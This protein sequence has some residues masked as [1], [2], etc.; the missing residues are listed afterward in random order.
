M[1]TPMGNPCGEIDGIEYE[2]LDGSLELRFS[3]DGATGT[4]NFHID[5]NDRR[6]FAEALT[7]IYINGSGTVIQVPPKTFPGYD[8]LKCQDVVVRGVKLNPDNSGGYLYARVDAVYSPDGKGGGGGGGGSNEQDSLLTEE[9]D[10]YYESI[11]APEMQYFWNDDGSDAP[12]SIK[13]AIRYV[14]I[15]HTIRDSKSPTNKK[16][17]IQSK[18]GKINSDEFLGVAAGFLLYVGAQTRRTVLANGDDAYEIE[19]TFLERAP[20]TGD[21]NTHYHAETNGWSLVYNRTT[22]EM[23]KPYQETAFSGSGLIG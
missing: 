8:A 7:G 15:R 19:H 23:V 22:G 6:S 5:W 17:I 13:G 14:L 2:E 20:N 18:V 21:W 12:E 9:M 10:A 4:R 1:A 11:D 3:K 16:A